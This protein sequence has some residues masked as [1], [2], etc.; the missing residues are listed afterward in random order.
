MET[1]D[2]L[3]FVSVE[4]LIEHPFSHYEPTLA[5]LQYIYIDPFVKNRYMFSKKAQINFISIYRYPEI[6]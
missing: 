1:A 2:L 4:T 6:L 3:E 5:S